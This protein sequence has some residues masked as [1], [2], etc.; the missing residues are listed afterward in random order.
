MDEVAKGKPLRCYETFP[1]KAALLTL[2]GTKCL[3][4]KSR[5]FFPNLP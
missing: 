5:F 2:G 4:L 3:G 1:L